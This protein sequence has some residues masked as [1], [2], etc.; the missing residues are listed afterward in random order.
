LVPAQIFGNRPHHVM[1]CTMTNANG[2]DYVAREAIMD[3]L[4]DEEMAKVSTS[5]TAA[6]LADTEEY[7]DLRHLDLGVQRATS[8]TTVDMGHIIPRSGVHAK[9]WTKILAKMAA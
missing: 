7:L 8:T 3:L 1:E 6:K 4:S 9:T 5:E 2:K